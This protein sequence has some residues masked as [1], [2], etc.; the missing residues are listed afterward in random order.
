MGHG[1]RIQTLIMDQGD[2]IQ[3]LIMGQGD[4]I[5]TLIMGQGECIQTLD[6]GPRRTYSNRH[7]VKHVKKFKVYLATCRKQ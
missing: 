3:T 2:R 1:E 5:Q 6:Y 7:N 4:R